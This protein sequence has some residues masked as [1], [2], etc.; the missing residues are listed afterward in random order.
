MLE[1]GYVSLKKEVEAV[2]ANPAKSV[3][4]AQ[5]EDDTMELDIETI[6]VIDRLIGSIIG[7]VIPG[8]FERSVIQTNNDDSI[9]PSSKQAGFALT[10]M[11]SIRGEADSQV[12]QSP[13]E[14][15]KACSAWK[16]C[17]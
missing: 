6:S 13:R 15:E 4:F 3:I 8:T 7:Q 1:S 5:S 10:L 9:L 16:V 17:L 14:T 12:S 2:I 11:N